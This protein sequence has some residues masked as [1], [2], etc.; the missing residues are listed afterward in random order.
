VEVKCPE[1]L[2]RLPPAARI[3]QRACLVRG[4][5]RQR[6]LI[7]RIEQQ[8]LGWDA[9]AVQ[10]EGSVALR[11]LELKGEWESTLGQATLTCPIS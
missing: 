10:E 4:S 5:L 6:S 3:G 7:A 9:A 2:S 8:G 11:Q 1:F